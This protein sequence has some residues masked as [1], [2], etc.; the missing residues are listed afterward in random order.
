MSKTNSTCGYHGSETIFNPLSRQICV[1]CVNPPQFRPKSAYILRL[2]PLG[3]IA[4]TLK[5]ARLPL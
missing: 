4:I 1:K 3:L 5:I 2:I